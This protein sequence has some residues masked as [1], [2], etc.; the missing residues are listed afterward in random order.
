MN[1]VSALFSGLVLM[2]LNLKA[3]ESSAIEVQA[4]HPPKIFAE[5]IISNGAMNFN[6]SYTEDMSKVYFSV[7]NRSW[8]N[9]TLCS[10]EFKNDSWQTPEILSISGEY[11]DA[12]PFLH[13][14]KLYFISD[15]PV[16]AE[17]PYEQWNYKIWYSDLNNGEL[18]NPELLNGPF[19][20]LGMP[21]YP[22]LAE[23]GNLYFTIKNKLY[24][25]RFKNGE[26]VRPQ[27]LDFVRDDI[28]YIDGMISSNEDF[29]V[30]SAIMPEG[31]GGSDLWISFKKQNAWQSPINLGVDINSAGNEG[32]P[33]LS[34][35]NAT[36]YF[37]RA[38]NTRKKKYAS[39]V[40]LIDDL[41]GAK[42]SPLNIYYTE[43]DIQNRP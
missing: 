27:K 10:S 12:D 30:F 33:G 21:L 38:A 13:N 17:V 6:V 1:R 28:Q 5:N 37:S 18:S 43:L 36:L 24:V 14:G 35:D 20:E 7:S 34:P 25:S 3:Q 31:L 29:I 8:N 23:N 22:S 26:Y 32:Q 41:Q 9:I 16:S 19:Y 2:G 11:L 42:N 40:D 15:R 4:K 39:Y